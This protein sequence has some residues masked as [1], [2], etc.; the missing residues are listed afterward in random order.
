MMAS[1]AIQIL[2]F[3][4]RKFGTRFHTNIAQ[5]MLKKLSDQWVIFSVI[6]IS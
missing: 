1:F 2:T 5:N 3:S 6:W 4:I